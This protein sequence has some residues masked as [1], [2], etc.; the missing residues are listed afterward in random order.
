MLVHLDDMIRYEREHTTLDFKRAPYLKSQHEELLRDVLAMANAHASGDRYII[1]G[2]HLAPDGERAFPG[3]ARDAVVDAAIYQQLVHQNIEPDLDLDYFPH[4]V[5]GTLFGV[6]R[7]AN[8]TAR[9]YAMR[10]K[11]GALEHGHL[12]I[13][14]G[15]H[16][17]PVRREDLERI[18][19]ERYMAA[20]FTG[21][22]HIGFAAPDSPTT[23]TLP[24]AGELVLR[25]TRA[26][27][28]IK[29]IL[30]ARAAEEQQ[31]ERLG[32][33]GLFRDEALLRGVMAASYLARP[34][35]YEQRETATLEANLREVERTYALEDEYELFELYS[36]K[37]NLVL[38]ND[39]TE[40]LEAA[41]IEL[42]IPATPGMLV[43]DTER[44]KPI[45][46]LH[47]GVRNGFVARRAGERGYPSVVH[48][49]DG[50]VHVSDEVGDLRHQT[51]T[52]AFVIS[53]CVVLG[54]ES[55]GAVIP[56]ACTLR[57]KNLPQPIMTTLTLIVGE[58]DG[59]LPVA[60]AEE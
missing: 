49:D 9:P 5:D 42:E 41:R 29:S 56:I 46:D 7:I 21:Q 20:G 43:A 10:K 11:F 48:H 47:G 31:R 33:T 15:M 18:Y 32:L 24:A 60:G 38:Q 40:H 52:P 54:P 1:C 35:P 3:V 2:V 23:L 8:C 36:H 12:W 59:S 51:Q 14:K 37:I 28:K 26:A 44:S 22:V 19:R 16:K 4:E 13:R 17:M 34:V 25:S 55:V 39:G 6:F 27:R 50:S 57:G 58:P 53:L 45:P 30:D